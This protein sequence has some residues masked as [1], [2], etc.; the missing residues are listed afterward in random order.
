MRP[1]AKRRLDACNNIGD[2]RRVAHKRL[3]APIFHYM[4]GAADDEISLGRNTSAFDDYELLPRYLRDISSIDLKTRVLGADLDLPFFLAPTGMSRLFHHDKEPGVARAAAHHGTMYSLST[5]G[6]TSIEDVA[7][8]TTGPKMFQIYIFKDRELTREFVHR[9]K[10]A[11]YTS[12]C[13]TVDTPLAGNRERDNVTGMTIPP[14]FSLA[15]LWSFA[16][17]PGWA[18]NLLRDRDFRMANVAHRV[19]ALKNSTMGLMD[20]INSQFD[21]TIT[22]DDAAWIIEEW[23]GPFAIKGLQT[24]DDARRAQDAGASAIMISNHGGRQLDTTPAPIDCLAPMRDA[25]GDGLELIVDGG[26]RRGS[27]VVKALALGAN[28]CSIGRPYLFG[29]AAGG[30]KGV[31]RAIDILKSEVERT[32]ALLGVNRVGDLDASVLHKAGC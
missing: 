18:F 10:A 27:H 7:G 15:S 22:W 13:L 12:M 31:S 9:C 30:E 24:A 32:M 25:V 14:R 19:D 8:A 28:A 17:H 4:D 16:S 2:L 6:T 20:Y 3:P 1:K 23:G 21:R 5:V 26:I 29:L 11:G